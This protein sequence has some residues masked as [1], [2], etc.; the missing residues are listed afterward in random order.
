MLGI[1]SKRSGADVRHPRRDVPCLVNRESVSFRGNCG[2]DNRK[3]NQYD[4]SGPDEDAT[5]S[6]RCGAASGTGDVPAVASSRAAEVMARLSEPLGMN[7]PP[8]RVTAHRLTVAHCA[9]DV[10]AASG[11]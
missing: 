9:A 7:L 8:K 4:D 2:T 11:D 6:T 10:L 5:A 3:R 1:E